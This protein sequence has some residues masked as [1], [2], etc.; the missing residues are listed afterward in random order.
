MSAHLRL[1]LIVAANALLL[2]APARAETSPVLAAAGD[3]ACSPG[4]TPTLTA[5]RQASTAALVEAAATSAVALLGDNQ[6]VSGTLTEFQGSFEPTWGRFKGLIRPTPGNHEYETSSS[7][8]GYFGYFGPAAG[9]PAKGYYSYDLGAWHLIALNS[10]C[11]DSSCLDSG[12]GQV[13]TGE[14]AWLNGDLAAHPGACTLAYWHH[15]LFGSGGAAPSPGVKPLWDALYAYGA[16]VVL[17]GHEHDYERFWP[18]DPDGIGKPQGLR[19][20]VVG[21]GGRSLGSFGTVTDPTS[22][23]RD[24]TAF[25]AG[26][27]TLRADGYDWQYKHEDGT[28]IDSGTAFCH[29][30]VPAFTSSPVP[31]RTGNAVTFDATGSLDHYGAAITRYAWDFGDGTSATGVSSQHAYAAAGTYE[32]RL[33]VTNQDG[34]IG[35]TRTAVNVAD[36][37]F[38]PALDS[39]PLAPSAHGPVGPLSGA[40]PAAPPQ[41][42]NVSITRR[43]FRVSRRPTP[44]HSARAPRGTTL[45]FT[46][47]EA[48]TVEIL[49]S[50][51]MSGRR[52]DGSCRASSRALRHALRCTRTR[53]TGQLTRRG[54][55]GHNATSFS[56]RIGRRPLLRGRYEVQLRATDAGGR[57]AQ[58][59]TLSFTVLA[60]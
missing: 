52:Q 33:T 1:L 38:S 53:R 25:G 57:K 5:C 28:L 12:V 3:I 51:V 43:R 7:A 47:S 42:R 56:G 18:K 16:D 46:L 35:T 10:N 2:P 39:T 23:F 34:L 41:I 14:V 31:G 40:G 8:V 58:P 13:T 54:R 27:F 44:I 32:V 22:A 55:S 59:R 17:N 9:D 24:N 37:A 4:M 50:R 36:P 21:T 30:P 20:F 26:F 11:S 45:R 15:P 49:I 48:A 6:Y 19:E 60:G 29:H